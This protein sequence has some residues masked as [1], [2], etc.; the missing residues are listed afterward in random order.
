MQEPRQGHWEAAM[1][2]LRYLK[3]TPGQGIVLPKENDLKLVAYC[4]SDWA[5]CPLTRRS[6]SGY[7]VKLGNAPISWKTKKQMTVSRSSS[8]AEYRALAHVTSE[9][10]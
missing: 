2:V 7:L 8:E 1:R 5:A 3:S 9:V 6:I 4:D 10:L